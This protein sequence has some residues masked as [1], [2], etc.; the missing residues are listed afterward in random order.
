MVNTLHSF[1]KKKTK[2]KNCSGQDHSW[3]SLPAPLFKHGLLWC[4][5]NED[6]MW[7][8]KKRKRSGQPSSQYNTSAF[9]HKCWPRKIEHHG[10]TCQSF[11]N[12]TAKIK[13][14]QPNLR[15]CQGK[16]GSGSEIFCHYLRTCLLQSRAYS[17]RAHSYVG[18]ISPVFKL[19]LTPH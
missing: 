14:W 19:H 6:G 18:A 2:E 13:S 9:V 1:I 12:Q 4:E 16:S 17:Q 7:N 8:C 11:L 10:V 15:Y 3:T 5:A